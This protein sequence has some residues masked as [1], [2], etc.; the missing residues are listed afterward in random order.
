MLDIN[1]TLG[2]TAA[3]SDRALANN[4]AS[5]LNGCLETRYL[6]LRKEIE[7]VPSLAIVPD[8]YSSGVLFS[9]LPSHRTNFITNNT[10]QGAA[11]NVFPTGWSTSTGTLTATC[12]GSGVENDIEYIDIQVSG[13][14]TGYINGNRIGSNTTRTSSGQLNF[15]LGRQDGN[16][17]LNGYIYEVIVYNTAVSTAQRQTVEGYLAWKW[18][19]VSSLPANH[20]YKLFPPP[21]P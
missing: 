16:P 6:N 11:F 3:A 17:F 13:T 21:P 2:E 7:P 19:L 10:M 12:I 20:P 14:A 18:N 9:Q 15:V 1:V 4:G 8:S 5:E